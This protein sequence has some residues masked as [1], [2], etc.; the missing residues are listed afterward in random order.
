M[1]KNMGSADRVIRIIVALVIGVLL[2]TGRLHGVLAI[3][4]GV[5]AAALLLT[6]L[7]GRC[8]GYVPMKFSTHK[9]PAPAKK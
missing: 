8:P 7:T 6:S 2:F 1:K 3:V 9:E 5:L 4:L